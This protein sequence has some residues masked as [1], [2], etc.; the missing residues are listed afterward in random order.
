[1]GG[2]FTYAADGVAEC[3]GVAVIRAADH[4]IFGC[5]IDAEGAETF[6]SEPAGGD[7]RAPEICVG[8]QA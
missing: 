8:I 6:D 2:L 1:M 4:Y 3:V 5:A 7:G